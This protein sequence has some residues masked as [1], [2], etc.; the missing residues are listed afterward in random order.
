MYFPSRHNDSDTVDGT[1]MGKKYSAG[2]DDGSRR[3][4][5][6]GSSAEG[7]EGGVNRRASGLWI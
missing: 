1:V 4:L 6:E 7:V 5:R 2:G 3:R